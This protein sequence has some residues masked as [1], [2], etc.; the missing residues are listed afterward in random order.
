[1]KTITPRQ[2]TFYVK[3]DIRD[4]IGV[5]PAFADA[6]VGMAPTFD[7]KSNP[8]TSFYLVESDTVSS[9]DFVYGEGNIK[10]MYLNL[11]VNNVVQSNAQTSNWL[12]VF[13]VKP[14]IDITEGNMTIA[15]GNTDI[16]GTEPILL[17][18][19]YNQDGNNYIED[20]D[21][22]NKSFMDQAITV[23]TTLGVKNSNALYM[24]MVQLRDIAYDYDYVF[25]GN[26]HDGW[27]GANIMEE[28][29]EFGNWLGYRAGNITNRVIQPLG[30]LYRYV[31][32][33]PD[34]F[35]D[36]EYSIPIYK[37]A[38]GL[39]T[40]NT[41]NDKGSFGAGYAKRLEK[42]EKPRSWW[43]ERGAREDD[44]VLV[45][46]QGSTN[47][48]PF[49]QFDE[50]FITRCTQLNSIFSNVYTSP[51]VRDIKDQ[52]LEGPGDTD[53]F[54]SYSY[55]N[56][57]RAESPSD[58][59]CLRMKAFWENYNGS[60]TGVIP[61]NTANPFGSYGGT[62]YNDGVFNQ[63]IHASILG[64]PQPTPIDITTSGTGRPAYAPEIEVT[65]KIND[66]GGATFVSSGTVATGG[67]SGFVSGSGAP[68]LD[69]SFSIVFND[70]APSA[71]EGNQA[72][73]TASKF[74]QPQFPA[75]S[76]F[77]SNRFSPW[78]LFIN[79]DPDSGDVNVY[80]N[81]NKIGRSNENTMYLTDDILTDD[82][83]YKT[84]IPMGEWV[85]MR[86]KLNMY[87]NSGTYNSTIP[88]ASGGG[89]LVYFPDLLESNGEVK[90]VVLA[91]GSPWGENSWNI[92]G[93]G[94]TAGSY[95]YSGNNAHYPN[96]SFWINNMRAIN[97]VPGSDAQS[98]INNKF[99]KIDD[100]PSDDKTVDI[101]ID[102]ISFRNWGPST[103]NATICAEN[104]MGLMSKIPAGNFMTPTIYNGGNNTVVSGTVSVHPTGTASAPPDNYYT[105]AS[106]PTASYMSFG[107]ETSGLASTTSHEKLLM[108]N[109]S[110][111]QE[112]VAN[113]IT[114]VSGGYFT[115]AN[116]LGN[117]GLDY[118]NDWFDNLTVGDDTKNI[119]ITG[120]AGS[121][122]NFVQK[123]T[124]GFQGN[125]DIVMTGWVRT[126]NPIIASKILQRA[127]DKMSITVDN[128]ELFDVP[129]N[130]PLVIE[131]NN[132]DYA[133]K[134]LGKGSIGYYDTLNAGNFYKDKPL[135][136]TRKRTG[137][138]IHLNREIEFCDAKFDATPANGGYGVFDFLW[139]PKR[140]GNYSAGGVDAYWATNYNL[141][142][143]TISPYKYWWN[144]AILNVSSSAG[145]GNSFA[146]TTHSGTQ[147]LQ[148]RVYDGVVGVSGGTTLGTTFNELLF[149]DGL[150]ANRWEINFLNPNDTII[151][152]NT[153]YG[154]GSMQVNTATENVP[155]SDG[156]AGRVGRDY[157][158]TGNNYINLGSYAY[159]VNPNYNQPFN[160]II[161][162]TYMN[163]FDSLY[164]CNIN[165][166]DATSNPAVVI[167][168]IE[169]K[170]P[171]IENFKVSPIVNTI[172]MEEPT[173]I[174][175]ATK[176][177]ATDLLFQWSEGDKDINHRIL[178]VDTQSIQNKYHRANFI[179][180]LNENSSTVNYYTSAANYLGE[181]GVA[182]T[183]T[184]V[185]N[186]EGACGYAF[187][188][189]GS[190]TFVSSS[191]G[192]TV[193]NG[194]EFTFTCQVK[195][196]SRHNGNIFCVSSSTVGANGASGF[197]FNVAMY[198]AGHIGVFVND[199]FMQTTTLYDGD[200]KQPIA[201]T[202]TYNKKLPGNNIK[203][204]GNGRLEDTKDYTTTFSG[205]TAHN[206]I[207][208]G[209]RLNSGGSVFFNG[210][211][212]EI[213]FH[214]KCA[215]V[216]TNVNKY[217][218]KT[219]ELPD[220]DLSTGDSNK[221][222]ARLFLYD[223]HNIRGASPNQVC[224]SASA[225]WKIT[226]LT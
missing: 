94:G 182:M 36:T 114:F 224:R 58:G 202:V 89:S 211:I 68:G 221:Y 2:N 168:G 135:L 56:L 193:G 76:A 107:Y 84:T 206:T 64:I 57:V 116:Y 146:N 213:T 77:Y 33:K 27:G 191:T 169:D 120:G 101:L 222:Q 178:W 117:Y 69:R 143:A 18:N 91:H 154:Y 98:N 198:S 188:G 190:S 161:K 30:S 97:Q 79:E 123:G 223:F 195:P 185:P 7:I 16:Y 115:A 105:Q 81:A 124:I 214:D 72:L 4:D 165:T 194:D 189:N 14:N 132:T 151:D 28:V 158:V 144:M 3:K 73:F 122:D 134:K 147:L 49:D 121:V 217:T 175:Q 196:N 53:R 139:N 174:N 44:S 129:L 93:S 173:E 110:V 138:V 205:A 55:A 1:M 83:L 126:G 131:L 48:D 85:R 156:G 184:N 155:D 159:T 24:N 197:L 203:L 63:T 45:A 10:E 150:Y 207:G 102:N 25:D 39:Y 200:G 109:F 176:S 125:A 41:G 108:S 31:T 17:Y 52:T 179:A 112:A 37:R 106:S 34:D 136:Q 180:P 23:K 95:S 187:G 22:S 19:T 128:P 61:I 42:I 170:V 113:P 35:L 100:I 51:D 99:T 87:T 78:I 62:L 119:H 54:I 204:Y 140:N 96:M 208:I 92:D 118:Q 104:G 215:Y 209:G 192:V 133:N 38:N 162:P 12:D 103:T 46:S 210:T 32:A 130:T 65:L 11:Y 40:P 149:N 70:D 152:L 8:D 15:S 26:D 43:I 59:L 153:D 80:T 225:S 66:M 82:S 137:N 141:T 177:Q 13:A 60:Y 186:I 201:I 67:G 166:K 148:T 86:I 226:G 74:W 75:P 111:G 220:I 181:T 20:F 157:V 172:G 183:G 145:W 50:N 88:N 127:P 160:F 21:G 5:I 218:G 212:D 6:Y 171:T 164:S 29:K 90:K 9:N 71:G 219:S 142:K 216:P 199:Q 47:F 167:Y 163:T